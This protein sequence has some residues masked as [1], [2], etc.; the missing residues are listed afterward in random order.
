MKN[1]ILVGMPGCGKTTI[2][3]KLAAALEMDFADTD[4]LIEEQTGRKIP[5]IICEDGEPR[6]REL[7]CIAIA[8]AVARANHVIATGGGS[9]LA[10][11]NRDRLAQSGIVIFLERPL[12][13][14]STEGRPLSVDLP[15]LYRQRLPLYESLCHHKI[16]MDEDLQNNVQKILAVVR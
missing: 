13:W 5:D 10:K 12:D 4:R 8:D 16:T 1:I 9:V 11:E 2:G 15:A 6:F 14:L 7:E 3:K